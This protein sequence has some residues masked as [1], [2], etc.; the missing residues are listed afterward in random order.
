LILYSDQSLNACL[1]VG[2]YKI[3]SVNKQLLETIWPFCI[4]VTLLLFLGI[5][6]MDMLSSVRAFV[7]GESFWSKS[8]KESVH[9]LNIYAQSRYESDYQRFLKEISVPLNDKIARI[10]LQKSRPNIQKAT[11]AF[12]NARNHPEDVRG[13][14]K[15]FLTFQNTSLL[16]PAI[17]YWTEADQLIE[18][19]VQIAE[20]I[21]TKVQSGQASDAELDA[22]ITQ[23]NMINQELTPLA[24]AFSISIGEASL[25]AQRLIAM[26]MWAIT[27]FLMV[28]GIVF[29]RR[30]IVRNVV[31][32]LALK[33]TEE[34]WKYALEGA[35]HGVWDWDIKTNSLLISQQWNDTLGYGEEAL[36][37]NYEQWKMLVH[38]DDLALVVS[39]LEACLN[40]KTAKFAVE[41]RLHC[42]DGSYKWVLTHG[43]IVSAGDDGR[44]LRM[45]GTHSDIDEQKQAQAALR[46]SD[47]NQ[48]ALLEAMV[49]GVFVAQ[50]YRFV[51][52]NPYLPKML[53]YSEEEFIDIPFEQVVAPDSLTLW[54]SRFAARVG[55]GPE[56]ISNYPVEFLLKGGVETIWLDL[57][58]SRVFFR[59]KP[60]VLGILRDISK[61]KEAED[62]I[63]HQ[64]NFDSLT[65]LPNRRMF[66]D[67]LEQEIK[68]AERAKTTLAVMFLD[69]DHFKEVNDTMGHDMGDHLLQ[70]AAH[71]LKT[72]VRNSDTVGRLGGDEFVLLFT[73]I[74]DPHCLEPISQDILLRLAAPFQ[75]GT[76]PVYIS[77]SIG[78]TL[79][80]DDAQDFEGLLKNADQAMYAAKAEGR[81]R[82]SYF[83]PSMQAAAQ[84]KM[85]MANDLRHALERHEFKLVYQP[86]I[87]VASGAIRKAEAL[88]RWQ[89]PV[90]GLISPAEFIP[91][92]EETGII[93][94]LGEWVFREALGQLLVWRSQ[95]HPEFQISINKSPVQFRNSHSDWVEYMK[96]LGLPG[97]SLVVEITES[98]LLDASENVDQKLLEFRDAGINVAIDDFGTGYSSLSYLKKFDIDFI[99]ID[100]SFIKNMTHS[101]GD[102]G[103]CEAII[104][105]AHKLGMKVIAEG[106]ETQQQYQLLADVHCDYVQGYLIARP[107]SA[108]DFVK[109]M[110]SDQVTLQHIRTANLF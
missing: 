92:A 36:H 56:P 89:H 83:T 95:L 104:L 77:A 23:V 82:Y 19:M 26:A 27:A 60:S 101:Q 1:T 29:T 97:K 90:K 73:N 43:M 22:L 25:K 65:G 85:R 109:F 50:D 66:R 24:N 46:E 4:I 21:H 5:A 62:M 39:A 13:M 51:F 110:S 12:I 11:Q 35:S 69:L 45:V 59:G 79:F 18:Q 54:A 7:S 31:S 74:K 94:E 40:G 98:L 33:N 32:A 80:P 78:I 38:P 57:H 44:P 14:A 20:Q 107:L 70:E 28:L 8:Q 55:E 105:M 93:V 3:F 34:R 100:Q 17:Q 49:D 87:E 41:Y 106:V 9:L 48:R 15:L 10:E 96:N 91:V 103:L 99:K 37:T 58:A 47:D 72:R 6:S 63:W 30:I 61:Q 88:L 102:M 71:R 42:K 16:K 53:G 76:D 86:I 108:Q 64:A 84:H 2:E 68:K 67:R 81:N 75:L 52:V